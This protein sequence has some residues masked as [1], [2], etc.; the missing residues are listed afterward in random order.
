MKKAQQSLP[1]CL[2]SFPTHTMKPSELSDCILRLSRL[3]HQNVLVRMQTCAT[4]FVDWVYYHWIGALTISLENEMVHQECIGD[5]AF[6]LTISIETKCTDQ[7]PCAKDLASGMHAVKL[8]IM[9]RLS[10]A[11]NWFS[12]DSS[13]HHHGYQAD[14]NTVHVVTET[15]AAG[16]GGYRTNL[17]DIINPWTT[18][19]CQLTLKE[20]KNAV[21]AAQDVV[22]AIMDLPVSPYKPQLGLQVN[23]DSKQKF[24]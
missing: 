16:Q 10:E 14:D 2:Q 23:L 11:K 9:S 17:Y 3:A 15:L 18:T 4:D 21:F 5:S 7:S 1:A 13:S 6:I 20:I 24:Q 12:N 22:R 8:T 19:Y